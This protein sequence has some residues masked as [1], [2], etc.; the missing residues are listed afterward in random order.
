M[1]IKEYKE[2]IAKTA[3]FP[4]KVDN[5]G[6]AYCWLGL[7]GETAEVE[8]DPR[9]EGN[10]K[11]IGDVCWYMTAC[12]NIL[13]L[14]LHKIFDVKRDVESKH[15]SLASLSEKIKKYYRDN[16]DL[17][18][19]SSIFEDAFT[20][21]LRFLFTWTGIESDELPEILEQNYNKLIKRRETGTLQGSGSNREEEV[22]ATEK[23]EV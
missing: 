6:L 16:L 11:E 5:F 7:M 15:V 2:I 18:Q 12:A 22:N 8:D 19:Y 3:I 14:D 9:S 13:N 17:S 23:L 4:S 20:M 21:H 1:D 10:M